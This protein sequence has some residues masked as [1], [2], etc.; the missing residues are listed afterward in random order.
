MRRAE[1]TIHAQLGA[2]RCAAGDLVH[3]AQAFAARALNRMIDQVKVRASR[4]VRDAGYKLKISDIKAAIRIN[5]ASAGRLRADAIGSGRP[6]P[7]I[8]YGARQTAK[9][10]TVDVLNGRKVIAHA[11][12]ATTPNGSRQVFVRDPGA[13]HKKVTKNGKPQWSALPI[14]K[15]YGPS[16]PDALANKAVEQALLAL[17]QERFPAILSHEHA[18]LKKRLDRLPPDPT[19]A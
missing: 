2:G 14:N 4:Y 11:F 12:I 15:K 9:G 10:V 6:I 3:R 8:Q 19:N 7:L 17:I 1:S 18:W 5:R 13:K 16:I